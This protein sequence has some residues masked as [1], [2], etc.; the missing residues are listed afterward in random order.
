MAHELPL[1]RPPEDPF[2]WELSG[3]VPREGSGEAVRSTWSLGRWPRSYLSTQGE[4]PRVAAKAEK[5]FQAIA[6]EWFARLEMEGR[7]LKTLQKM[8]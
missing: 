4:N 5:T 8:R 1:P 2:I 3:R 6:D 7:A